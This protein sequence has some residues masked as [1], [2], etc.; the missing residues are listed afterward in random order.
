MTTQ[1]GPRHGDTRQQPWWD[2]QAQVPGSVPP[3]D[4]PAQRSAPADPSMPPT[5]R[6][7]PKRLGVAAVTVT[8]FV[9]GLAIGGS[10]G[11]PAGPVEPVAAAPVSLPADLSRIESLEQQLADAQRASQ[12]LQAELDAR[13]AEPPAPAEPPGP[14]AAAPVESGPATT[15][16]DGIYEVGVDMA[17]GRYKT[18]GPGTDSF[19][20]MCYLE[21]ASDDLGELDSII[22]NDNIQGPS[23][24]TVNDGEFAKFSGGCTW[25]KQ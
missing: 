6:R 16:S 21:R 22:A 8:V 7:W 11:A 1:N 13:P 10:G 12:D 23:S 19:V 2:A 17:A 18:P 15:V 25:T 9:L 24:L 4:I 14:V 5:A 20:G 3:I